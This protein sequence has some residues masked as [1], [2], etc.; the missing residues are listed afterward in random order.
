MS[1]EAAAEV[2]SLEAL[3]AGSLPTTLSKL[4]S[5]SPQI[6]TNFQ[7]HELN[8]PI[9]EIAQI[10]EC[11]LDKIGE[12]SMRFDTNIDGDEWLENVNEEKFKKIDE[13][14]DEFERIQKIKEDDSANNNAISKS[15]IPFH[16]A[17]INKPQEEY[18]IRVNNENLPFEHVWLEKS[19][20]NL[21]FVHP[22][23]NSFFSDD[24]LVHCFVY[25]VMIL[26]FC[27]MRLVLFYFVFDYGQKICKLEF[28]CTF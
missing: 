2:R 11:L 20:D 22:L 4:S 18:K 26:G 5:N 25:S 24:S 9:D 19:E 3:I 13:S 17:T 7:I 8:R 14:L 12:K 15:K 28:L 6:P 1:E 27:K 16:V 10:S 23:V 21:R